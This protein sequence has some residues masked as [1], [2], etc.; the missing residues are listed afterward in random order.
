MD[1]TTPDLLWDGI[2]KPYEPY[3]KLVNNKA[4]FPKYDQINES[5]TMGNWREINVY[6]QNITFSHI[7]IDLTNTIEDKNV[8]TEGRPANVKIPD[9]QP[10]DMIA[11]QENKLIKI[12]GRIIYKLNTTYNPKASIEGPRT[13]FS[14]TGVECA[15]QVYEKDTIKRLPRVLQALIFFLIILLVNYLVLKK[16]Q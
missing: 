1:K 7:N 5:Q 8:Y 12:Q 10:F 13:Y 11:F 3:Q 16:Y 6:E 15:R 9:P 2:P 4:Y 14:C